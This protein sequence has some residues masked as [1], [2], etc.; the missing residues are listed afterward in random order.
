MANDKKDIKERT[1]EFSI[2]IIKIVSSLPKSMISIELGKQLI[3]SGTSIGANVVEADGAH[4]KSEFVYH[5]NIAK[6]E[7]KETKYW[8][9]ILKSIKLLSQEKIEPL[10]KECEEI[11]KILSK[12]ILSCRKK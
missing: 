12:I 1:F 7:A 9:E 2:D 6:K 4:T 5:I 3:R 8:L 11:V 10:L